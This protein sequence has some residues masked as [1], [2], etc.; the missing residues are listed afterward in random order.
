MVKEADCP[1]C[2][3]GDLSSFLGLKSGRGGLPVIV[4]DGAVS[5]VR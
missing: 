3:S 1:G 2:V 5:I 4:L